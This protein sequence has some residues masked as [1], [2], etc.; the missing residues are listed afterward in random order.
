VKTEATTNV[1]DV[2]ASIAFAQ[3]R[4]LLLAP[5][6]PLVNPSGRLRSVWYGSRFSPEYALLKQTRWES[7]GKRKVDT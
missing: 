3:I 5:S 1:V 4:R 7:G 6:R 2:P